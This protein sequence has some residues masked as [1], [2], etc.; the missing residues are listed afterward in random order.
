MT[1]SFPD[2]S[3]L[4]RPMSFKHSKLHLL[5]RDLAPSALSLPSQAALLSDDVFQKLEEVVEEIWRKGLYHLTL[6]T[7]RTTQ[8]VV[9]VFLA[10]ELLGTVE[11]TS[12]DPRTLLIRTPTAY[13]TGFLKTYIECLRYRIPIVSNWQVTH[14]LPESVSGSAL[15]RTAELQRITALV[16]RG[17][18]P[19]SLNRCRVA[20][21]I[22]KGRTIFGKP[23]Y[24]FDY[25]KNWDMFNLI[26]GKE[27]VADAGSLESTVRREVEEEL[28]VAQTVLR[29][30]DLTPDG[31]IETFSLLGRFGV[32]THYSAKLYLGMLEVEPRLRGRQRWFY[33]SE[34][35]KRSGAR[36]ERFLLHPAY[37]DHLRDMPGGLQD[38]PFSFRRRVMPARWL[39][40]ADFINEHKTEIGTAIAVLGGLYGLLKTLFGW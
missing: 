15:L 30:H 4:V 10:L 3:L 38:L 28:G 31:P 11:L 36:G 35:E 27:E 6:R 5:P 17:V 2:P 29:L 37:F 23:M 34:V 18:Q 32:M 14:A 9:G 1:G 26:G 33:A 12:D 7:D 24:L 25:N 39:Q 22:I 40:I 8:A 19:G 16:N 20:F 21:V 13:A